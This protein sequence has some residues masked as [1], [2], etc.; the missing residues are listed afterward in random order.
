MKNLNGMPP[1]S[2]GD[3]QPIYF[4]VFRRSFASWIGAEYKFL[5]NYAAPPPNYYGIVFAP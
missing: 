5:Q 4:V 1:Q 3:N 2:R